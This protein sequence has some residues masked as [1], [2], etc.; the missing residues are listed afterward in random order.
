MTF[1][2]PI[3]IEERSGGPNL[4]SSFIAR[5]LFHPEPVERA[6]K[7]SRALTKLK[8]DLQ[9]VLYELGREPRHDFLANWVFDPDLEDTTVDLRLELNSGSQLKRFFLVGYPALDRKL[10]FCPSIPDLQFELLPGQLLADRALAVF[11]R[12]FRE[13]EKQNDALNL[14]DFAL[15]GKGSL[16]SIEVSLKPSELAKKP[17]APRRAWLFGSEE[18]KDGEQELRKTGRSLQSMY[19]DDLER[20]IGREREVEELA[21]L[22]ASPDR[23]AILLVGPRKAG[24]TTILHELAWQM[25]RRKKD[26]FGGPRE[27]WLLS[28]MRLIS[29]MSYLGEWENRILAILDYA[30]Q[31]DRVLYFDDL[32]GL[33][34]AGM[35]S[36]SD[37]NVAQVLRPALEK[38]TVRFVAEITPEAWRVLRERDRAFADLFDIIPVPEPPQP[39]TLRILVNVTFQLE[40]QYRCEFGIDLIPT[41]YDLHRRFASDAAFP[42]KAAG[43]LRR[44]AVRHPGHRI[45]REEAL[46]GF[47]EQSGM[48]LALLDGHERL[49]RSTILETLGQELAGQNQVLEA[50]ADILVTLKAR[51]N[52]LRRPLGTLLLLGPTGVGKTQSAK[53]LAKFLFGNSDRLLRFDMNEYVDGASAARLA[54]TLF[55]PEGLL[56]GAVRR[57]PFSVL[58]FDE[59][60]K[61]APEVFDLLLAVLDEGRLTDSLGRVADFTNTVILLTSNLGVRESHA[62][63]GFGV[64]DGLEASD[65]VF[66]DAAER[67]FRPE[68]FNRLDR[69]IP[70]RPLTDAHL[71]SIARQLINDVFSRDGLRRREC[72][73]RVGPDALARLAALGKDP[74]LGARAL[75]RVIEREVAQPI[76]KMLSGLPPGNPAIVT[77]G[78]DGDRLVLNLRE[79]RLSSRSVFWPEAA[80]RWSTARITKLVEEASNALD[81]IEAEI[82]P[83]APTGRIEMGNLS[84]EAARYFACREQ[85]N[86]VDRLTKAVERLRP[87]QRNR[88]AAPMPKQNP[89]K[90]VVRQSFSG[91][92]KVQRLRDH[93]DLRVELSEWQA[94]ESLELPDTPVL[95][96]CRELA[97]LQAMVQKPWND[98]PALLAFQPLEERDSDAACK[99]A[100][101]YLDFV[102]Y[103]W[104]CT[105]TYIPLLPSRGSQPSKESLR[106]PSNALYLTGLNIGQLLTPGST[107]L[108]FR[109][110]EGTL[111][112]IFMHLHNAGSLVEAAAIARTLLPQ[113]GKSPNVEESSQRNDVQMIVDAK[114][115]IDFR[116]GLEIPAQPTPEEFRA[117]LLSALPLPAEVVL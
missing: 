20:A 34:T 54:G 21:R 65:A 11:T 92:P 38:R 89:V 79:L 43:F 95:G 107:P 37:L 115:I 53:V 55:E 30:R 61:A 52:D 77:F 22:M 12:H 13:L 33:L 72:L 112:I 113:S 15:I 16:T 5:P 51:L 8:G 75:K 78:T 114:S 14:D 91:N 82:E 36:A 1:S 58:L 62:R 66:I 46:N 26:H 86:K 93:V 71:E 99:L 110:T 94:G 17:K 63:L 39:E 101:L 9:G 57:Q 70:F 41:V 25:C 7:L 104:G 48:Q 40:E 85:L 3:Y 80:E 69:I 59:I 47:R 64:Q 76:G 74:Q 45:G 73:L 24:K 49:E 97:L 2:I 102:N 4:F 108:L 111:G 103:I 81:R 60:E 83:Y 100:A 109:R 29:G 96:L 106:P 84:P 98:S 19:P 56:T 18:K 87:A 31:K 116:T 105:A 88:P 6:D 23:R 42:G 32:L 67:F 44:L 35:S 28:P 117:F 50:F 68:F 27:I 10:F 90:I